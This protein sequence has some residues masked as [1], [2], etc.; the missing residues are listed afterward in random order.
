MTL[1]YSMPRVRGR[2]AG[3]GNELIPWARAFLAAQVVGAKALPPAFGLNVRRYWRHFGTPRYDW[4]LRKVIERTLPVVEFREAD[5][6]H[7]GGGDFVDVF[8]KFADAKC[9]HSRG[10]YLLVTEGMWGGYR[11]V[12]AARDFIWSTLY[13]SRFAA[14][15]LLRIAARLDQDKLIVAMHVRLGDFGAALPKIAEYQ[16]KFNLALPLSWYRDIA[17]SIKRI[18]GDDVQFLVISDGTPEQLKPLLDGLDAVTTTDIPDSDCS[19]LLALARADLLVCSVSSF[20]SMA[21]F[22]SQKPYLWFEP[23]LQRHEEGFYSIWGH[24]PAQLAPAGATRKALENNALTHNK[25]MDEAGRGVPVGMSGQV[26]LDLLESLVVSKRS[27]HADR[28]LVRYGVVKFGV[29]SA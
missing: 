7:Y 4:L 14:G 11:H 13:Q 12:A 20:S 24:E 5:Y 9:L 10:S 16:G 26:P 29:E 18:L 27:R 28:D 15:N 8:R 22:L 21:A 19:D 2:G 1:R 25:D 6:L 23:N 17:L 3:L